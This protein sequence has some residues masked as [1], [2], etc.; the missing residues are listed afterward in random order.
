VHCHHAIVDLAP[1]A[2]VLTA[3]AD[4]LAATLA[5]AGLIHTPNGL[6]MRVILSHNLLAAVPQ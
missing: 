5:D 3:H 1:I 2:V 6:G 4:G